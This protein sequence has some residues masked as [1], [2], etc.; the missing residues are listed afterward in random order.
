MGIPLMLLGISA[1][2]WLP[3]SGQWMHVVTKSFGVVM[4]GM[5]IWLLSRIVS[6]NVMVIL[7]GAYLIGIALFFS[8]Y[9]PRIIGRH[10]INHTLGFCTG[11]LGVLMILNTMG[12][13]VLL[14]QWTGNVNTAF[15]ADWCTSCVAMDNEVFTRDNVKQALQPFM[16]VRVDLSQNTSADQALLQ[17]YNVIAPP[18]VLFFSTTGQEVNSR[19][20]V[21]EMNA[22]DFLNRINLFLAANCNVK[23]QC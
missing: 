19:R 13:P 4:L 16:L 11:L 23:A 10:K 1:G 17:K 7:W 12:I 3:K 5:A 18:T 15:Y 8:L 6:M 14:K 22:K 20:I 9:L 21:G 2:R